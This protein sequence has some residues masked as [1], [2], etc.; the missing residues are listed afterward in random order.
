MQM[1]KKE[2]LYAAILAEF[3]TLLLNIDNKK[4]DIDNMVSMHENKTIHR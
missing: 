4:S 3:M 1:I 2:S